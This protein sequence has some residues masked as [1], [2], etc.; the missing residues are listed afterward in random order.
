VQPI[1]FDSTGNPTIHHYLVFIKKIAQKTIISRQGNDGYSEIPV[2][3]GQDSLGDWV[4]KFMPLM[5]QN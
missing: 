5:G 2:D 1:F 3:M 4:N